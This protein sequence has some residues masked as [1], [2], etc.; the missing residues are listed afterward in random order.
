[1]NTG[2]NIYLLKNQLEEK[3]NKPLEK[4]ILESLHDLKGKEYQIP[5]ECKNLF[6]QAYK[7]IKSVEVLLDNN[8]LV[9]CNSL[10]RTCMENIIT[11]T[12]IAINEG[13][14]NEFK[15]LTLK[16][17]EREFSIQRIR[18]L[19][20]NKLKEIDGD[21]FED[22]SNTMIQN[23][24]D[25]LYNKLCKYTH[26][27]LVI[28]L[29]VEMCNNGDDDIL[30]FS[31]KMILGFLKVLLNS[32]MKYFTKNETQ[33]EYGLFG[34]LTIVYS[35]EIDVKKY[36]DGRI[37]KYKELIYAPI[38]EVI[39]E[40]DRKNIEKVQKEREDLAKTI[41]EHPKEVE[42]FLANLFKQ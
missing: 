15:N 25:E 22:I 39:F 19:F 10:L 35:L 30:K 38:N 26:S 17:G 28:N 9:D 36:N 14:Y 12:M 27:S 40:N 20:K 8:L 18:N 4:E 31:V 1:M 37:E 21:L 6:E 42:N 7:T 34:L 23:M 41:Q 2:D 32:C 3:F 5:S 33:I 24:L 16:D 13:V 11:S 29:T